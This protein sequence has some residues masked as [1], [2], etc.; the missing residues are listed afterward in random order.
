MH[1]DSSD[2]RLD[3]LEK[4]LEK[5]RSERQPAKGTLS[6]TGPLSGFG[7]AF[8]M[9]TEL[10][11]ALIVGVGFGLMLDHWLGTAPWMMIVFFFLG[12]AAGILNVYRAANAFNKNVNSDTDD[13]KP[14]T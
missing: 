13:N 1:E 5:A 14:N 12:S 4:R 7:A 8:R 9:G 11:A 6:L 10:L 3:D 2:D